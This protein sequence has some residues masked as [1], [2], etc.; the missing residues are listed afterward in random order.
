M[1]TEYALL[2]LKQ[3][4]AA[5]KPLS[6][7]ELFERLNS[8][9]DSTGIKRLYEEKYYPESRGDPFPSM[10]ER[11]RFSMKKNRMFL[12]NGA[13]FYLDTGDH[14]EYAT[15]EC[16]SSMDVVVHEK[17]GERFINELA[18]QVEKEL[19]DLGVGG[20]VI[21]SKNNIDI[22]GNTYGCHENY[23]IPR[24]CRRRNESSFFKLVIQE[25][26]PFLVTRQVFC[27]AGKIISGNKLGFQVSQRADFIDSELSSDTTFRRGIINSRDEP[28][29]KIDLYRRLHILIGDSNMS[30]LCTFLKTGTTMIVLTLVEEGI[31]DN[32]IHLEDPI[33]ALRE[34]SSDPKC[35]L[36]MRMVDGKYLSA[37]EIQRFYLEKAEKFYAERE[38]DKETRM[39]LEQWRWVLDRLESD[40]DSL[41]RHVDWVGKQS[42]M[43]RLLTRFEVGF[44][45]LNRWV[46]IIKRLKSLK[47]EKPLL[48]HSRVLPGLD[49]E[50]FLQ[51][52]VNKGD[53]IEIKRHIRYNEINLDRFFEM[54]AKYHQLLKLDFVFHDI[55][56]ER[57]LF[58]RMQNAGGSHLDFLPDDFET[59]IAAALRTPPGDTRAVVRSKFINAV[60]KH[61]AKGS[62]NWDSV[63]LHADKLIKINLMDPFETSNE[64]VNALVKEMAQY[65]TLGN[66][67]GNLDSNTGENR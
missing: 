21:L 9:I 1:E 52:R 43:Q 63:S 17:A 15:P 54:H 4:G 36:K 57:G 46:Y 10:E 58:Q 19:Q 53:F 66:N 56:P 67:G 25:L 5:G 64:E 8:R 62:V 44:K 18:V 38:A 60:L 16:T 51:S 55:H 48:E 30:P 7:T 2:H 11:R 20:Q 23:L 47:L 32:A 12:E 27:G 14:P 13:R 22:R 34:I 29:S 65:A 59:R 28:L 39:V 40:T 50:E 42:A 33:L 61:N 45:E 49:V 37:L 31:L 41:S 6:G 35:K 26:I 24:R 3:E